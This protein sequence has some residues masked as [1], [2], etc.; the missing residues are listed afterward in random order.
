MV[1]LP[2]MTRDPSAPASAA[3]SG[4]DARAGSRPVTLGG[5]VNSPKRSMPRLTLRLGC[6]TADDLLPH[7]K[8]LG[9]GRA[10]QQLVTA[11]LE[12]NPV[13]R[14]GSGG[15]NTAVRFASHKMG[16]VIQAESRTVAQAF[17]YQCEVDA[18]V[19]L[20]L[21]EPLHLRV[22]K[23]DRLG[24]KSH[25][26]YT[27]DYLVLDGDGFALVECKPESWLEKEAQKPH[28][29]YVRDE[30][31]TWRFPAAEEAA[32]ELGLGFRVFT[33]EEINPVWLR[34]VRHLLDFLHPGLEPEGLEAV[35]SDVNVQG[36]VHLRDL[37]TK[38]PP[39]AVW[40][41]IANGHVYVDLEAA[42]VGDPDFTDDGVWVH[43]SKAQAR[44]HEIA[45][46]LPPTPSLVTRLAPGAA[47]QWNGVHWKVVNAGQ[48]RVTIREA[49][50]DRLEDMS[51]ADIERLLSDGSLR[52]DEPE[53]VREKRLAREQLAR[54][55]SDH[56]MAEAH[57]RL[58]HLHYW[59]EHGRRPDGVS[60]VSM[61]KIRKWARE[62]QARYGE[63]F[64]GLVRKRGR[65]AG[66]PD[67]GPE[68]A[69]ILKRVAE[70]HKTP[71]AK[72]VKAAWAD[73]T[74]EC[75]ER[76]LEPPSERALR[77]AL[78]KASRK[79]AIE[80][81]QGRRAA[82]AVEGP[83]Q[84]LAYST[85]PHGDRAFEVGHI[86]H[87]PVEIRI[88]CAKTG[89]VLGTL[90]LTLL[91]D[92]YSRVVLAYVLSFDPP[93]LQSV[94]RVL[95]ECIRR[96]GRLPDS[97]VLDKAPEFQA[98]EFEQTLAAF[99]VHK[100]ERGTAKPRQGST[101]E[102][103]F[104]ITW[105]MFIHQLRGNTQ[106]YV[107]GRQLSASHDP[108]RR[109][110]W[111]FAS[112]SHAFDRWFYEV[113]PDLAHK[114]LGGRPKEVFRRSLEQSGARHARHIRF[115]DVDVRMRLKQSVNGDGRRKVEAGRGIH[116]QYLRYW[117]PDFD[118]DDVA[119]T[120]VETKLDAADSSIVYARVLGEWVTCELAEL[121]QELTG[122]SRRRLQV[123]IDE[124]RQLRKQ[125]KESER[126]DAVIFGDFLRETQ[127][128]EK[129]LLLEQQE[130]EERAL[131]APE[132]PEGQ[133]PPLPESATGQRQFRVIEGALSPGATVGDQGPE[134]ADEDAEVAFD[135]L[136]PYEVN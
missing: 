99:R 77:R 133:D 93:S 78:K 34:N 19:H 49:E 128:T 74:S 86:D 84:Y 12:G 28:P 21:C 22:K 63:R 113:Y 38:F 67:M 61:W 48:D 130:R 92:A 68:K 95:A 23:S 129:R 40:T 27:P 3:T 26:S 56:A 85:P 60:R 46:A 102:R 125:A 117:H 101:I 90:Y 59:E 120:R 20:L 41:A 70:K 132:R 44:E 47:L 55:T 18:A 79:K 72:R 123:A 109:A 110:V 69:E 53:D 51:L 115:E 87:S 105:E 91:T 57:R 71:T 8:R 31:G 64:W 15:G 88:V 4:A 11:A 103:M 108:K 2:P 1:G 45:S 112:L 135:D 66:T 122:M 121:R 52:A 98:S 33:S 14:V 106:L 131:V 35:V 118:R 37:L 32:R 73:L 13:R 134:A 65:R 9:S 111:T 119:G 96:H 100:V 29:N 127:D 81:R 97:L 62:G 6:T 75:A 24:R 104:G 116:V 58:D 50:T 80:A 126:L 94:L 30:D 17:C 36:S 16:R 124:F 42:F 136:A 54:T 10:L 5:A 7:F 39:K 43:A 89:V 25:K 76:G 83:V 114:G 82:Y 107:L